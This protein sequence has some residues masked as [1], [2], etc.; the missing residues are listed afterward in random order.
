[1]IPPVY[2]RSEYAFYAFSTVDCLNVFD[3]AFLNNPSS[4]RH[5][6]AHSDHGGWANNGYPIVTVQEN[7]SFVVSKPPKTGGLVTRGTVAE[8]VCERSGRRRGGGGGGVKMNYVS[9]NSLF[10]V[11]IC[12]ARLFVRLYFSYLPSWLSCRPE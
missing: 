2:S 12:R 7:G 8:Q 11:C 6:A 10:A 9:F 1:M 5:L 3:L 4:R